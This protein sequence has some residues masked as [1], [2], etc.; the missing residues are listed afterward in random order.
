MAG[1]TSSRT[2]T[3]TDSSGGESTWTEDDLD[4]GVAAHRSGDPV[5]VVIGHPEGDAPAWAWIE[6]VRRVGD[7]LQDRLWR[8]SDAFRTAK[9]AA[10]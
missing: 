6:S 3:H 9:E 7:R 10:C 1:S 5:P 8:I 2:G 4:R